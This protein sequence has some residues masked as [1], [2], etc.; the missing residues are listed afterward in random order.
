MNYRG[1][2]YKNKYKYNRSL[3]GKHAPNRY[4][5]NRHAS[6]RHT[7]GYAAQNHTL[8][9]YVNKRSITGKSYSRRLITRA[10]AAVLVILLSFGAILI[11]I[12]GGNY[13]YKN[14][15]LFIRDVDIEKY[16]EVLNNSLP[17]IKI[18][19]NSG[20]IGNPISVQLKA[21]IK[22]IFGF[23]LN[24][25][26]T[27][28]STQSS[29][30][31]L[32]Y[33][34]YFPYISFANNEDNMD[35]NTDKSFNG[36]KGNNTDNAGNPGVNTDNNGT[37]SQDDDASR[38]GQDREEANREPNRNNSNNSK[39]EDNLKG[40]LDE[41]MEDLGDE[42]II[43]CYYYEGEEEK[44]EPPKENIVSEQKIEIMNMTNFKINTSEIDK[45]LKEPLNIKFDRKGPKIL[46]LHTHTSESFLK[47]LGDL[48]KKGIPDWS[49]DPQESVVR[50]GHEL[51]EQ[52]KKKYGYDVVHNGTVH[53]RPNYNKSYNNS[54]ET[55]DKYLKSYPSIKLVLDIH[56]DGLSSEQPKLRV[57]KKI[58]GKDVAQIMFVV[59]TNGN[60]LYHP[61]WKENLK[62]A[63]KLQENLNNQYPGLA[64]H[65]Y[66]SNNR[67][68]Q[69]FSP[70][71]L[72]VEI[73][74]NGNLLS[75]C[76]ESVK[77]L[78]KA[79]DEVIK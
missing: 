13:V 11:G 71:S 39:P 9:R 47:N 46:I 60:G 36:D 12:E 64:R 54:Y 74:G 52:F 63:I 44:L 72:T 23:D 21:L 33:N 76:L 48:N 78:T 2:Y 70:G 66:I 18:T 10:V 50:V 43:S 42:G 55:I 19:Y 27:I 6:N 32:Y 1:S 68:N 16:K 15:F 77:Y 56:R 41:N 3:S 58:E 30:L 35:N 61:N 37:A 20:N 26:F 4:A 29:F 51:A 53:D 7:T 49:S 69:Q 22:S 59:G 28:L 40:K 73:G 45:L 8:Y 67:Y 38:G 31:H 24:S 57:A 34:N 79:I 75:E 62:L 65:I 25:P 14:N 5:S 17:I